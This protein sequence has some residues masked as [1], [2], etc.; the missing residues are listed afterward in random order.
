[1]I[2]H[3][4]STQELSKADSRSID[5]RVVGLLTYFLFLTH[6]FGDLEYSTREVFLFPWPIDI[7]TSQMADLNSARLWSSFAS[8]QNMDGENI[9]QMEM[10]NVPEFLAN[11]ARVGGKQL[12]RLKFVHRIFII[13]LV[14]ILLDCNWPPG[15]KYIFMIR[16]WQTVHAGS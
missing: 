6:W 15:N 12:Q 5:P 13:E 4:Q 16:S 8:E 11:L 9:Y 3:I 10:Q 7:E 2:L 14:K 1:M